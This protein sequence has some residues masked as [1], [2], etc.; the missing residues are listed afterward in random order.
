MKE[1]IQCA[2]IVGDEW[3]DDPND[4][5]DPTD[6][7]RALS[8]FVSN[9]HRG[10]LTF[11]GVTRSSAGGG[12]RWLEFSENTGAKLVRHSCLFRIEPI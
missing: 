12:F 11:H 9:A 1:L 5:D 10:G 2:Q 4:L 3:I 6:E 7:P 8:R